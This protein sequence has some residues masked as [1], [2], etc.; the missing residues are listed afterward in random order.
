MADMLQFDYESIL[1]SLTS[2]LQERLGGSIT[3]GSSIQRML[4]VISEKLAQVVRYSEYLTRETKWSLA[5]NASSILTQLELFG[6]SPHRKVGSKGTVRVSADPSFTTAHVNT[7][8]IPKFTQFSNGELTFTST[9]AID[10]PAGS[11]YVD[12]PVVQGSLSS[13]RFTGSDINNYRYQLMN[14]SIEN[15]I[16]EL[17]QNGI[18][19]IEVDSF[20]ETQISYNN[21][22]LGASQAGGE[23][24]Y[25]I[26]NIQGFEGIELQFPSGDTYYPTDE[27]IFRYLITEGANGNVSALHS[28]T[29]VLGTFTDTQGVTVRL[30]CDNVSSITGG[31]DYETI[32]EM[33]EGAPLAFNRVDKY[34]TKNDYMSAISKALEGSGVFYIWTEQEANEQA[35]QFLDSYNFYNNSKIFI[36]GCTRELDR[37]LVSWNST[38][39]LNNLN[40]NKDIISHKGL[41]DYFV[42]EDPAII[43]F[44]LNGTVF[45]D[46]TLTDASLTRSAVIA[47]LADTYSSDTTE[48]FSSIYHSEYISIFKDLSEIDHVDVD[49]NLYMLMDFVGS[50]DPVTGAWA[51][52]LATKEIQDFGFS[53][54][55]NNRYYV[56][57]YDTESHL[58]VKDLAYVERNSETGA[59]QWWD[60]T[61][62]PPSIL[63]EGDEGEPTGDYIGWGTASSRNPTAGVF[64]ALTIKGKYLTEINNYNA[65]NK[66]TTEQEGREIATFP[67][68]LVVRFQPY[69]GDAALMLQNQILGLTNAPDPTCV[70]KEPKDNTGYYLNSSEY[71]VIF[72]EA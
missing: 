27:F 53:S 63:G 71:S 5:Q 10:L 25:K 23:Y 18:E 48:F 21:R 16:Y 68:G 8:T 26:R 43:Y 50:Q 56:T 35:S 22:D 46:R 64:G 52:G 28:V 31:D 51:E 3:G 70:W 60:V 34:I 29:T 47:L 65:E 20:G 13:L 36:C 41:T 24:E 40:N 17:T 69:N 7:I 6:Y 1:N 11:A 44:Y 9:D 57:L 62:L 15:S 19:M 38:D 39:Q 4:E 54:S 66:S 61:Q 14:N 58:L 49:I 32:D 72:Q 67:A 33:R 12:V 2:N 30:Y 37:T 45:F 42:M 59:F 55:E